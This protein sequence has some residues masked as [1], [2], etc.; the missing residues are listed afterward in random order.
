[1]TLPI[2]TFGRQGRISIPMVLVFVLLAIVAL[3]P[4]LF[5][6]QF[7]L[8]IIILANILAV[9][10]ISWDALAGFMGQ[11]NLGYSMY[12]GAG[13]YVIG[14]ASKIYPVHPIFG[15]LIGGLI[16]VLLSLMVGVPCLRLRGPYYA[17]ATLGF[18]QV[19]FTL[20]MGLPKIT[21]SE[22]GIRGI[23]KFIDGILGNYYFSFFLL[24]I[25]IVSM[26]ILFHSTFGKK[27]ITL[28]EDDR[29]S[30][31]AG[32]DTSKYKIMGASITAFLAGVAGAYHCY[33]N[34]H[35]SPDS[36]SIGLTFSTIAVV[37][38]GGVGT[39]FGP[40]LGAYVLTFL[41]EYFYFMMEYRLLIYSLVIIVIVLFFPSGLLELLRNRLQTFFFN[42]KHE[43]SDHAS[44]SSK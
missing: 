25:T 24:I 41:N 35:V 28:R 6:S 32:I 36:L 17:I 10:A 22:E 14:F 5:S 39:L 11:L 13:A 34:A 15:L 20:A 29:L 4:Q 9:L 26:K 43:A 8:H 7:L 30:E 1:M 23:P 3:L 31:A 16:A 38:F 42:N 27:L 33:Y 2:K 18:S 40:I 37:V 44:A 21:G 19:L 12:F